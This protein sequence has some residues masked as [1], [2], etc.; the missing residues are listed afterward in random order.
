VDFVVV[1]FGLGALGVLLGVVMLGWLAPRSQR[2]AARVSSPEAAARGRAIAAEHRG[3][4][5]A[6][7]YAGGAML[8]ATVAGLVGSLDDRTGALLVTTTATVSAVGILLAGY[9]QRVRNPMPPRRAI[10]SASAASASSATASQPI[11]TLSLFADEPPRV[12][13]PAPA[14]SGVDEP[15]S[16]DFAASESREPAIIVEEMAPLPPTVGDAFA[17]GA[18]DSASL[19]DTPIAA[20]TTDSGSWQPADRTADNGSDDAD[21]VETQDHQAVGQAAPS[22]HSPEATPS[23]P[24]DE[25]PSSGHS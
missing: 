21:L 24:D 2:A 25:D 23:R 4:G 19:V 15:R 11:E 7:L 6:F 20:E 16:V 17:S 9:L 14:E 13:D 22:T 18:T 5:R 8:L 1:G 10:R 3:T 12:Q